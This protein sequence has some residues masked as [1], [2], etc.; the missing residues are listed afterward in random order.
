MKGYVIAMT[1]DGESSTNYWNGTAP[2]QNL[3]EALFVES[4]ATARQTAGSL[5]AGYTDRVVT[6]LP[7]NKGIQL[8][9]TSTFTEISSTI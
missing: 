7:G 3:D 1:V 5:Q 2:V 9:A 4:I 6:V 8:E